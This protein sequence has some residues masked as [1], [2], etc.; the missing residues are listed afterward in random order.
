MVWKMMR[1]MNKAVSFLLTIL[2]AFTLISVTSPTVTHAAV[3]DEFTD[4]G[5]GLKFKVL[6]EDSGSGT[7]HVVQST[8]GGIA[9]TIPETVAY[10]GRNYSVIGIGYGAFENSSLSAIVIPDS[11]TYIGNNAFTSCS[12]LTSVDIPDGV[13][14]IGIS[15]FQG[16]S[17]SAVTIPVSVTTIGAWSFSGCKNLSSVTFLRVTPPATDAYVFDNT[18]LGQVIVPKGTVGQYDT[19]FKN[20]LPAG[21]VLTGAAATITGVTV[22]PSAIEVIRGGTITFSAIVSGTGSFSPTVIWSASSAGSYIGQTDGVLTVGVAESASKITITAISLADENVSCQA[23]VTV[24]ASAPQEKFS[25]PVGSTCYFDLSSTATNVSTTA[26]NTDLPDPDLKW[27]P[28][29]YAGTVDAYSLTGSSVVT[30]YRNLFLADHNIFLDISWSALNERDLIYGKKS[31]TANGI[32]Y[33]L[34]SISVGNE[35]NLGQILPENNEWGEILVKGNYIK[36]YE[37]Y[38]SWGQDNL[39]SN[40]S[41]SILRGGMGSVTNW[42]DAP[43]TFG[44]NQ[45][46]PNLIYGFRP[47]LEILNAGSLSS[48]ALKTVTYN[49][50]ANGTLGSGSLTSAA[51]VY[52]GELVLPEITSANGFKYNGATEAGKVLGWLDGS[53]FYQAGTKISTLAS[54]TVLTAG[55]GTPANTNNGTGHSGGGGGGGTS[56]VPVDTKKSGDTITATTATTATMDGSGRAVAAVTKDQLNAAVNS[57]VA[58]AKKQGEGTA[59]V[60]E[61]K[62]DAPANANSVETGI[63]KDAIGLAVSGGTDALK[64]S[65]PVASI[66]FDSDALASINKEAVGDVKITAAK[67]DASTLTSETK[68][69]VGDRPVFNF[70]VTSGNNTISEFGGNV[71]VA[72]PY[73]PKDGEDTDA[74][75]IYYINSVGKPEAVANCK[76]DPATKTVSFTT[77]HFSK[78]AVG[79]NKVSFGDVKAGAWYGNAVEFAAARGIVTGMGNGNYSP[80]GELTRGQLLVMLMRAYGIVPDKNPSNNFSDAG[81]TYY[82]GYLAAAKRLGITEGLGNNLYA[83]EKQITRQEMFALLYNTLKVIGQL[84]EGTGKTSGALTGYSD[85]DS[86]ASW[87]KDASGK[88]ADAG[89]ISGSNG[90]LAPKSTTTRAE[91]AQVLYNLLSK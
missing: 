77:N 86:V 91:M 73:T 31:Y 76:Y 30:G 82:T 71:T 9:Y 56:S 49:M 83:P 37:G 85:A 44:R 61:I 1:K 10:N 43:S 87:A 29:T 35:Y 81:N 52:I 7:V 46:N 34:R 66:S 25:L 15:A 19:A 23:I 36:N 72:V 47:A 90:K 2:L 13:G 68:E 21:A 27:T 54:G 8:Y 59:A 6:T 53:V 78:Y 39:V 17:L 41:R 55:Y 67:V 33:L 50:G 51:V 62:V 45:S 64:V 57:A 40:S 5:N 28:F 88:L 58:E 14:E 48:D 63:P 65:T 60:V 79:Y 24:K 42:K 74:I 4:S 26:I 38:F 32:S 16:T 22:S 11:I 20:K 70:S 84:P 69:L 18:A 12:S 3:N 75:V 89:V 80:D